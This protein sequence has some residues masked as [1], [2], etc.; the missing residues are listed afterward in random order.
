MAQC[1]ICLVGSAPPCQGPGDKCVARARRSSG[2]RQ[3]P[4]PQGQ[5]RR[6]FISF[7]CSQSTSAQAP[8]TPYGTRICPGASPARP[9]PLPA[10]Y[11]PSPQPC[12]MA[13]CPSWGDQASLPPPGWSQPAAPQPWGPAA[14]PAIPTPASSPCVLQSHHGEI[15]RWVSPHH[16]PLPPP[17]L[18]PADVWVVSR[19]PLAQWPPLSLCASGGT[20]D[21]PRGADGTPLTRRCPGIHHGTRGTL[22]NLRTAHSRL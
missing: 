12:S 1:H 6:V 18:P 20:E 15:W 21:T 13:P 11:R 17:S 8:S 16:M 3:R 2:P 9:S 5:G 19:L 14:Q 22:H 10:S 4:A 7:I